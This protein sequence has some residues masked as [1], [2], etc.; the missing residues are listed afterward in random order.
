MS[1]KKKSD[2]I[3]LKY[4]SSDFKLEVIIFILASASASFFFSASTTFS[5]APE[6]NLSLDHFF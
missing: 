6:I 1:G 5:G 2:K 4:Y 3:R